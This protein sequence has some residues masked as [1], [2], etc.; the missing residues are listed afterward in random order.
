MDQHK[1]DNFAQDHPGTPFPSIRKLAAEELS[2]VLDKI[3]KSVRENLNIKLPEEIS[4]LELLE[5]DFFPIN[6]ESPDFKLEE[7]MAQF[8]ISPDSIVYINWYRFD[9]VDKIELKDLC[10]YFDYIWYPGSDDIEIF[11]NSACWMISISHGG[12][13]SVKFNMSAPRSL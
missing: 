2:L 10:R 12:H 9:V 3:F 6:A 11:D 1:I 5:Q 8:K 7:V 4:R 13:T